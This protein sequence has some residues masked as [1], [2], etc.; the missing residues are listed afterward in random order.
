MTE[1]KWATVRELIEHLKQFDG[2]LPVIY[3]A[4]SDWQRLSLDEVTLETGV[5]K[6]H[7]IM[8]AYPNQIPTMSE[9]NRTNVRHFVAFPGN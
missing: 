8:R 5:P 6:T 9:E 3:Q 7:Y 4:C 1:N 2:D